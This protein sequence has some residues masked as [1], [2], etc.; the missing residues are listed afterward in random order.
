[1]AGAGVYLF[2]WGIVLPCLL[3][4]ELFATRALYRVYQRWRDEK[5]TR[6]ALQ[7]IS[8]ETNRIRQLTR[9]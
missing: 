6:A 9:K 7:R 2:A 5:E 3:A 8:D 1:M 4:L